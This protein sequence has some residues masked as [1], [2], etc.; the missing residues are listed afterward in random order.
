VNGR[1]A[2]ARMGGECCIADVVTRPP[3]VRPSSHLLRICV[4][5][6]ALHGIQA[7]SAQ[8]TGSSPRAETHRKLTTAQFGRDLAGDFVGLASIHNLAPLAG[9]AAATALATIPEQE[10]EKFFA[11]GG[12]W[13]SWGEAG[14]YIGNGGVLG[15]AAGTLFF[16]SRTTENSRFRDASYSLVRASI[17]NATVTGVMKVGFGRQRPN[18]DSNSFPSGHSSASFMWATVLASHYGT[19][20]AIPG[21]IAASYVAASRLERNKHHLTD[22]VAGAVIGYIAGRTVARRTKRRS[23]PRVTWHVVPAGLGAA[24]IVEIRLP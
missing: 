1:G 14:H 5:F 24:A 19:K 18:G 13:G 10:L 3:T 12:R 15:A 9:G 21:F 4:V 7:V 2:L 11:P 17:V 6:L 22:V 20:A 8:S 23:D 16:V